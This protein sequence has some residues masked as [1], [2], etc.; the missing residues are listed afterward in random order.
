M[1]RESIKTRLDRMGNIIKLLKIEYPNSKCS[2]VYDTPF[3]LLVATILSAQCTDERVNRVTK[4]LFLKYP[5]VIDFVKISLKDLK[6]EIYSTG[7]YNNKAKAIHSMSIILNRKYNN[8]L[9]VFKRVYKG[10]R[11]ASV[12]KNTRVNF[13]TIKTTE[14]PISFYL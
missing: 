3:Q 6:K 10:R 14:T 4:N 9:K 11:R 1:G 12:R 13:F 7:F 8:I 2:L 5:D